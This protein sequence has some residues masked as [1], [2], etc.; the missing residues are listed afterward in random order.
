MF[1]LPGYDQ[2][3]RGRPCRLSEFRARAHAEMRGCFGLDTR[4][5]VGKQRAVLALLT[6]VLRR[7]SLRRTCLIVDQVDSPLA[8]HNLPW[9]EKVLVTGPDVMFEVRHASLEKSLWPKPCA[10]AEFSARV[11]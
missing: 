9:R 3:R 6:V 11:L 5:E 10:R 1:L 8:E 7:C 4:F 2:L